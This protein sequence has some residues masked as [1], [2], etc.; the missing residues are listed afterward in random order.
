MPLI[1]AKNKMAGGT[2]VMDGKA[3]EQ[4]A[5]GMRKAALGSA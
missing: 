4:V 5:K 2:V 1:V 3:S